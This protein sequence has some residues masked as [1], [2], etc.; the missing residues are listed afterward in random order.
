MEELASYSTPV[1]IRLLLH[2]SNFRRTSPSIW[3]KALL[4]SA[5]RKTSLKE[6][7]SS[8]LTVKKWFSCS[9]ISRDN[10][11]Y[12]LCTCPFSMSDHVLFHPIPV[13][14]PASLH[15][16]S[17]T[18]LQPW[19]ATTVVPKSAH[20]HL[21]RIP[22]SLPNTILN[23]TAFWPSHQVPSSLPIAPSYIPAPNL[24][25]GGSANKKRSP[26]FLI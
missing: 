6:T 11:T 1:D 20:P 15:P 9:P 4:S 23:I 16:A 25:A 7:P 17:N 21:P 26:G 3:A 24:G 18:G 12:N 22:V 5:I 19:S 14:F 2:I 8:C 13:S 10:H